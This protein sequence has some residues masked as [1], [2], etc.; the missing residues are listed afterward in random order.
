V[1]S[2][3]R[4]A[5]PAF[6]L[7]VAL[8]V[9]HAMAQP[10][11]LPKV[12]GDNM[13]LQRNIPVPVWGRANPGAVVIATLGKTTVYAKADRQGKWMLHFPKITAGGPY[14]LILTEQDRPDSRVEFKNILIGDVWVAS[15][16][17]NME[18]PVQQ[19]KNAASEMSNASYPAIRLLLV[20]H[21][22][23]LTPQTDIPTAGWKLADSNS[24]KP[25]SAVAFFF[26]R[27]IYTE[28]HIPIGII[29]STWGGTPIQ[30]WTSKEKLRTSPITGGAALANDTLTDNNFLQDSVNQIRFWDIVSHPQNNTDK[31]FPIPEYND[32]GWT[33]VNMPRLIK[34]FGI[35]YYEGIM[36][37]RKTILLPDDF[38]GKSITLHLGHPEMNYSLYFNGVGICQ[39]VWNANPRQSYTIPAAIVRKGE[40]TIALRMSMLWGGGGLNPPAEDIYL[41][42][43]TV[44]ISLAGEWLYKKDLEPLPRI[45]NYQNYPDVLFNAM[46]N[47]LIPYGITGFLWYQGEANDSEA[48]YYRKMF[49]MMIADWRQRWQRGNL[50]FLFVQLANFKS[51]KP[52]PAESEWAELREAQA[53][54]LSQPQTAMACTIDI[55]ESGDIH[56]TDKQ[57]VGL[58]LALC[59]RKL[60]YHQPGIASGPT[61]K[62]YTIQGHRIRIQF[63]HTGS[64]L[65]TKDGKP[66]TGF[67]IAGEDKQFYWAAA[68][69]HGDE[70]IVESPEVPAPKAVRYAWAD[71]PDCNLI[72]SAGLPA[73]PFRT[74]DWA[75]ITNPR[76]PLSLPVVS[77]NGAIK[78][79][80]EL[81]AHGELSYNVTRKSNGAPVR[82]IARSALGIRTNDADLSRDLIYSGLVSER[83]ITDRYRML[84][85]KRRDCHNEA[86]EKTFRFST[87]QGRL[88]DV[89]FR[90]YDNGIAFRYAF[91][92]APAGT[93][94][95]AGACQV[96]G[97][98]TSFVIPEGAKRWMQQYTPTYEALY[99]SANTGKADAPDHQQWGFPALYAVQNSPL[100]VLITEADVSRANCASHL[101]NK[102]D[103]TNYKVTMPENAIPAGPGWRSAWRILMTGTLA[104]IVG[105]T[106]V[107][108][109]S[110]PSK[111]DTTSW[112]EPGPVAW[113]YW[114]FN[115][116][117]K[118]YQKVVEYVNLA[119]TMHW[120]YVL[121]DWEWDRMTNGGTIEDAVAY[122]R[123]QGIKPLMW[124]NS[125]DSLHS[126]VGLDPYGRLSTHEARCREFAWLNTIGV[127]G[128]KV[129]FFE[130]DR[131]KEMAYYLDL[132]ADAAKAHLLVDFH[133]ATIPK[134]WARTYPNLM[135]M[136][137]VYGAEWY[138]YAPVLNRQGAQHNATLPFT[139]NVVGSM[140][141]TPVTFT[142]ALFPHTTSYAHEL[143]L[144]V[145]FE[146]GLQHF[147]DR[148]AG[149]YA[150]PAAERQFLMTLPVAWDDTRLI[151]G[152]PGNRVIIARRKNRTWYIGGLNGEDQSQTLHL[153]LDFLP[154]GAYT[155][156]IIRDGL[157]GKEFTTEAIPVRKGSKVEVNCL[158][159]GGFAA[160]L[161]P[162]NR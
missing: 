128:V 54:A 122:A 101:S 47:P 21:A 59:A 141:Y 1:I 81:D 159:R 99:P 153:H 137:A 118:D 4:K 30:A 76:T 63:V 160:A 140:D 43:S 27:K 56:P 79:T 133:G 84:H 130:D 91:P 6:V 45:H 75:G 103:I 20:D 38:T 60:V 98:Q 92:P 150:L 39:N 104:D 148:P 95:P 147:A 77:P 40:N 106:L 100:W 32:S 18:F 53:M 62:G 105:S 49:P 117:S 138:A 73:V 102:E 113:V 125:R 17:S 22:K 119:K 34:D 136:E 2:N 94:T 57:D 55:G 86:I 151:D 88:L 129:D 135:T 50:P 15:G 161:K 29:Q 48:W 116:G 61:Y 132:L 139:R 97:E 12:F 31:R 71:N 107:T 78:A 66:I 9:S 146:S 19:A 123:S 149:F 109:V 36:W 96:T 114:A 134:G 120:P 158:P 83:K 145:V 51:R 131:Q 82:A 85:G 7:V 33:K 157:T 41:T 89:I 14:H 46:I 72:N 58:R 80:V 155:L 52:L 154:G 156:E 143:A 112:I 110:A 13:V 121:I 162:V 42:D 124:Y 152:F 108:D 70:I 35:G 25:F 127:A 93:P 8:C 65:K 144:S 24:V 23:K 10:L 90:A 26:A 115:H 69:I 64:T 126:A 67:A 5:L 3:Y 28:Q 111:L 37:L 74:D 44:K 11:S 142:D 16:Q 87:K 68:S